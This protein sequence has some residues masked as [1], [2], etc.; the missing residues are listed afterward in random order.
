MLFR[1]FFNNQPEFEVSHLWLQSYVITWQLKNAPTLEIN[2]NS[3]NARNHSTN[4][5]KRTTLP[6]RFQFFLNLFCPHTVCNHQ[7]L[8]WR[9]Q[10]RALR[11]G[12]LRRETKSR[13]WK[14]ALPTSEPHSSS[15]RNTTSFKS[16]ML[17]DNEHAITYIPKTSQVLNIKKVHYN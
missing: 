14:R 3:F 5:H 6:E 17:K 7:I 4:R 8:S 13:L 12:P 15:E 9:H 1:T 10:K 2:Q 16:P 11:L